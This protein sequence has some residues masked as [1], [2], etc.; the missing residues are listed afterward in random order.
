MKNNRELLWTCKDLRQIPIK[1][2]SDEHLKSAL[3][4]VTKINK[5]CEC[6]NTRHPLTEALQDEIKY[7]DL[8][9]RIDTGKVIRESASRIEQAEKYSPIASTLRWIAGE[10]E[11]GRIG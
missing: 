6:L 5:R 2:L 3:C 1:D 8:H 10:I 4:L 11:R 9:K 7:R